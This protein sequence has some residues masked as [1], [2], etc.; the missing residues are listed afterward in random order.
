MSNLK[1]R[2]AVSTVA[3]LF[4][5]IAIYFSTWPFFRPFFA[6]ITAVAAS[7]ALWEYYQIGLAKGYFPLVKLGIAVGVIYVISSYLAIHDIISITTIQMILGFSL[8]LFSGYYLFNNKNPVVSISLTAFG[9][10]YLVIPIS[11]MLNIN[12]FFPENGAQDGRWWLIYLITVTKMTDTGAYFVGKKFGKHQLAR[13]ISPKKTIEGAIGGLLFSIGASLLFF[14]IPIYFPTIKSLSFTFR[15]AV[16]LGIC[17]SIL[18]QFGD[19]VES[20]FKRDAGIKDSNQLPGLGG[21]L[22]MVDSLVFTTPFIYF[23]L[24]LQN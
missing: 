14:L 5:L 15:E 8:L 2:L 22:D 3:S 16:F 6:I 12:Y 21:M 10:L 4:I 20:L 11:L 13:H 18:A 1:Q 17:L 24:K 19:L 23:F 7:F 9:I